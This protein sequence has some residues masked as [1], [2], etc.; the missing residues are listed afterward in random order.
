LHLDADRAAAQSCA[1]E[2]GTMRRW[3]ILAGALALLSAAC[4]RS[5]TKTEAPAESARAITDPAALVRGLYDRYAAPPPEYPALEEEPW[6][7][8][9]RAQLI[10]MTARSNALNEPILDFDP[11]TG[12]Q[13]GAV[14]NLT[15]SADGVVENSHA[16][17]RAA[18]AL[19]GS[20]REILYDLR[21]ENNSW[22]IDN[23]RNACWDL[24]QIAG[25]ATADAIAVPAAPECR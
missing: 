16:V 14:A 24:R 9:L 22:R 3:I 21:W 12:A 20:P 25:A 19:D 5:E 18:F 6:T 2:E 1:E 13:D 11:F 15:V 8:D 4:S 23:V 10:A 7:Q 17:V